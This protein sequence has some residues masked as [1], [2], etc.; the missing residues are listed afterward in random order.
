VG[1]GSLVDVVE[2]GV[3]VVVVDVVVVVVVEV[4]M[5]IGCVVLNWDV[6][7]KGNCGVTLVTSFVACRLKP[8]GGV[9]G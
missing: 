9:N 8:T 2:V 6:P 7:L 4:G 3:V 5:V 1:K